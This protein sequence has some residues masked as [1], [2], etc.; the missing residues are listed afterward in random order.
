MGNSPSA[1]S[2]PSSLLQPP[3]KPFDKNKTSCLAQ[4]ILILPSAPAKTTTTTTTLQQLILR[5]DWQRVLIRANL[6]PSELSKPFVMN[7]YDI[8][9]KITPLHLV[10]ALDPPAVVVQLFLRHHV[11]AAATPLRPILA[12]RGGGGGGRGGAVPQ[13]HPSRTRRHGRLGRLS[14]SSTVIPRAPAGL[15]LLQQRWQEWRRNRMGAFPIFKVGDNDEWESVVDDDISL[16]Q[17]QLILPCA[18]QQ[19]EQAEDPSIN[20]APPP[21]QG[22]K[23]LEA[24]EDEESSSSSSSSSSMSVAF[25]LSSSKYSSSTMAEKDVILQLSASGGLTPLLIQTSESTDSNSSTTQQEGNDTDDLAH[26]GAGVSA[27]SSVDHIFRMTWDLQPL[28]REIKERGTL[29]PLHVACLYSASVSVLEVLLQAYPLAALADVLGMLPIHWVAGGWT[30]P[31]LRP[32]PPSLLGPADPKPGPLQS[33][34]V[35]RRTVPE[36]LQVRSGNHGMAAEDYV[37]ECMQEGEYKECCMRALAH[38]P[39]Y[40]MDGDSSCE[41]K[42]LIFMDSSVSSRTFASNLIAG[43]HHHTTHHC[44]HSN[45]DSHDG[46]SGQQQGERHC[47]V[48]GLSGLIVE[49]SWALALALVEEDPMSASKWHYGVD[50]DPTGTGSPPLVWKRLPIHLACAQYDTPV[51]FIE[52]LLKACPESVAAEDPHDGNLPLHVACKAGSLPII[53]CLVQACPD[54]TMAINGRGQVPLHLAV[55]TGATYTVLEFLASMEPEGVACT[56]IS[57]KTP[58]DYAMELYDN[59]SVTTELLTM[60]LLFLENNDPI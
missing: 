34:K 24:D 38:G 23:V 17:R 15:R 33:L 9:L 6:F 35:L 37:E 55:L 60:V 7:L 56:D 31:A 46:S 1:K 50:E 11:D 57:G 59:D 4:N 40:E 20:Y 16:E 54:A 13:R 5:Q 32:P 18:Q 52:V 44:I 28:E 2:L 30:L 47:L 25:S 42:T 39:V 29:L 26:H 58:V 45:H 27:S 3:P 10:C 8:P 48:A 36:S 22:D 21:K 53:Q 49:K 14:F 41:Y 51:G 43:Q 12:R 19:Q